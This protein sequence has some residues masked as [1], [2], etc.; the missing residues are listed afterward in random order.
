M[1]NVSA[2]TK[3]LDY[4]ISLEKNKTSST[5]IASGIKQC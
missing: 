3:A 5:E 1:G 2:D 4:R